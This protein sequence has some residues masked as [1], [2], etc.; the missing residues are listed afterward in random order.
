LSWSDVWPLAGNG[1]AGTSEPL[2]DDGGQRIDYIFLAIAR[3]TAWRPIRARTLRLLDDEVA[4][5]SLSDHAA[6]ECDAQL[7]AK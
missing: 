5:G 1:L 2:T 7:S 4:E 3:P 6:V